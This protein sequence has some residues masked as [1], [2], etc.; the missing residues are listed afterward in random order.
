MLDGVQDP[1]N[2]G[3]CLR[4][5]AAAGVDRGDHSR[6]TRRC[7]STPPC[8]RPRPAPPTASRCPRHQPRAHAAR[9]A[10]AGRVDL[11]PGR[12]GRRVALRARPARQRRAGAGR[13]RRRPAPADAR[14]L[15]PAGEDPDAGRTRVESLNVSVA[16]GVALFEAVRQRG[17]ARE[18]DRRHH[19]GMRGRLRHS[20]RHPGTAPIDWRAAWPGSS[21]YSPACSKSAG[22]SA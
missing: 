1:H 16:T 4:S 8:A 6:R 17:N 5:A 7:R 10:E 20:N 18:H 3:A 13:R 12:R 19:A 9:P 15:R 21:S 22:R 14:A 11:R 2:L